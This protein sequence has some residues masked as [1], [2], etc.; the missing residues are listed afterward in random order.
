MKAENIKKEMYKGFIIESKLFGSHCATIY[1][2]SGDIVK[3]IVGDI[4][5][6][7]T[8]N[9]IEKSKLFIDTL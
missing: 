9:A 4:F 6:D 2:G 5:A 1:N 8:H 7:G 3:M